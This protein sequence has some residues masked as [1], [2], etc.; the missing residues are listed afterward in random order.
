MI[1]SP[2]SIEAARLWTV[3]SVALPSKVKAG[4]FW[5]NVTSCS[6]KGT[7]EKNVDNGWNGS[8]NETDIAGEMQIVETK[9]NRQVDAISLSTSDRSAFKI[10]VDRATAAGIPV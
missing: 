7:K 4:C 1:M 6:V 8:P 5:Q 10:V 9:I 2:A 3:L